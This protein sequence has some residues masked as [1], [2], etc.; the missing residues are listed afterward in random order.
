MKIVFMGTPDFAVPAL[1]SLI[2]HHEV[3][4]VYTQAPKPA[5]KGLTLSK[6]PVHLCAEKN[7][8][9]VYTPAS[10][11]KEPESITTFQ[12]LKADVAVVCAYGLILPLPILTAFP[13]GCINIH[14]SLLPRWRG[15]API[16]RAIQAG[17]SC[18]GITTMQMDE[19][20]DTGDMLLQES[21][22]ITPETTGEILH[23]Q[24]S[25]LGAQLIIK[26]LDQMPE[27]RPQPTTGDTY[28]HK[29]LKQEM[30]IDWTQSATQLERS[31]RAFNPYPA[32][33]FLYHKERIKVFKA[34]VEK[35]NG[36]AGTVLDDAGL[37][38]CQTDAIRLLEV[39]KEG[40]RKM[41]FDDFLKGAALPKG[42]QLT[43]E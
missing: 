21:I 10:F 43:A 16:Q 32:M 13:K 17:D 29:I 33:Y 12:N 27:P 30:Q 23:D 40:K 11:K 34:R 3:I 19:G 7:N 18:S 35:A 28:A 31:I 6:S 15:A 5:G 20:L 4:A 25:A 2:K 36:L 26:T 38:A 41:A 9:P 42:T 24:L 22:P 1:E 8:I 39:Q 14:A 37:I